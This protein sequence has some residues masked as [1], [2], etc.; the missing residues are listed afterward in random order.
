MAPDRLLDAFWERGLILLGD[1]VREEY[2][3]NTPIFIDLRHGL[4][5]D[6][7]LLHALGRRIHGKIVELARGSPRTQQV[8]GIPDTATPLALAA[9]LAS[10]GTQ[11]P[12]YY[13]QLRKQ[14]AA[15]PGGHS[16]ASAYMGTCDPSRE[17]TLVD[18]VIASGGTKVWSTR[19]LRE[20]GLDVTRILVVVDREQGGDLGLRSQGY[21]VH[22]LYRI[23]DVV[24]YYR[25]RGMVGE[26]TA[27]R[28]LAHVERW[29]AAREA[30]QR[31]GPAQPPR[32]PE[33]AM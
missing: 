29:R 8:I 15:Y 5:D 4:Y 16:G 12:L 30:G 18:D 11:R 9:A 6:L 31:P 20:A 10:R 24:S 23:R 14:P 1:R 19:Y 3:L 25:E 7:D 32:K 28:A 22:S 26:G 17:I 21:P 13:G 2:A 33:S 27:E